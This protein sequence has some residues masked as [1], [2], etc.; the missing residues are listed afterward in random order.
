MEQGGEKRW[1]QKKGQKGYHK[2]LA[3]QRAHELVLA[4]YDL[5][6]AFP[7]DES[8]GLTKQ[9][10]DA[11]VSVPA[12]IAEGYGRNSDRQY[13]YHLNVAWGSLA[14]TEYY[15]E[16]ALDLKYIAE[17]QYGQVEALRSETAYLLYRLIQSVAGRPEKRA[18]EE[19]PLS[20]SQGSVRES[21][22][23][24]DIGDNLDL[25]ALDFFYPPVQVSSD[26][27][28][29]FALSAPL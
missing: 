29:P 3:W 25:A 10:R 26:P 21:S 8:Y 18:E 27:S 20:A 11:V 5:A 12:N 4:V 23:S 9:L 13:L 2:L 24:Y 6:K 14:E 22:A 19:I 16:L 1:Q 15:I 28:A 7:R 17:Q